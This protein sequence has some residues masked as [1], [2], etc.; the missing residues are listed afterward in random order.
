M[1]YPPRISIVTPSYN[2]GRFLEE[3][4]D[5]ILSQNYP[6]LEYV[7][8]D[9]GSTD[10]SVEIIR[11]YEKHLTYWQS[12]PDGGHYAAVSAG[13]THTTGE[14]MAWL[15]SDDKY[16]P[17]AFLKI[18]CIFSMHPHVDWLT[19]RC[20]LWDG[21]GNLAEQDYYLP[22][23]SRKKFLEGNYSK[24]FIVQESTVWRRRLWER[25]GGYLNTKFSL[26][27]DF[28][29]WL[30]FFRYAELYQTGF[31]IGGFRKH[32]D[33]RSYNNVDRYH[34]ECR[35]AISAE[36]AAPLESADFR[37]SPGPL[38]ATSEQLLLYASKNGI[39]QSKTSGT[40]AWM[41]YLRNFTDWIESIPESG[42]YQVAEL[43][44]NELLVMGD[45]DSAETDPLL[46]KCNLHLTVMRQAVKRCLQGEQLH[47]LGDSA[48]AETS[49][50]E[51][52]TIWSMYPEA[53][54][55][56]G[57]LLFEQGD[58]KNAAE[59]FM[60]ATVQKPFFREPYQNLALVYL[61]HGDRKEAMKIAAHYLALNPDDTVMLEF[62]RRMAEWS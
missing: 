18:A 3:C 23:H 44:R 25:A 35:D 39:P 5:S 29:L 15:N 50:H 2:Q 48:A 52:L 20:T 31:M 56:K 61:H 14:I 32:G 37:P 62:S 21:S 34:Q 40:I 45:V 12:C 60:A 47:T 33:Q 28:E 13:F 38:K 54:N 26:A 57:V 49:L 1:A 43:L 9:G 58:L 19:G 27:A 41:R 6:N 42:N 55:N 22:T 17:N 51:A 4:I 36:L 10:G 59:A 8:M 16:H 53:L 7:I 11:K 46:E 24:P 30:R